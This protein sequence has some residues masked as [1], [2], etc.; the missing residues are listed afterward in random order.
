MK[1][2]TR[3]A[4]AAK[5]A[6]RHLLISVFVA[7]LSAALVFFLLYPYPYYLI[8][9]SL[10]IF[11]LMMVVDVSC[12][13]LCT[14]V[15]ASPKKSKKETALDLSFIGGIQLIALGYGLFSLYV[16][17]PVLEVYE[18]G[19]FRIVMA[20]EVQTDEFVNALPQFKK[21]PFI[22]IELAGTRVAENAKEQLESIGLAMAGIEIGLRPGWWVSYQSVRE[23]VKTT[24]Q[25]LSRLQPKLSPTENT[26]LQ[27]ALNKYKIEQDNTFYLP[28]DNSN[29]KDWIV[30]LDSSATI[31]GYAPINGY[32][33]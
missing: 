27:K 29:Y 15:V 14:L 1:L 13:P 10:S 17:R 32:R 12:G 4:F 11:L 25:P 16:A 20:N 19:N 9:G 22:G 30:L 33:D 3:F 2:N 7:I 6:S 31:I 26:A 24:Y 28:L 18:K 5:L 21:L 23:Q 8:S